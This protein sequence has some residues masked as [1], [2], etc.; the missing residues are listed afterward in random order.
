MDDSKVANSV[1][2]WVGRMVARWADHWVDLSGPCWAAKR[3]DNLAT[4]KVGHLVANLAVRWV[5]A[6]DATKAVWRAETRVSKL[7]VLSDLLKAEQTALSSA[8]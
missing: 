6:R 2:M 4:Q 1:L 8:D 3:A 7:V 5:A